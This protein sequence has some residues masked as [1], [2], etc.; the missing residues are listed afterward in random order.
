[1][2]EGVALLLCLVAVLIA[3]ATALLRRR[4]GRRR[5]LLSEDDWMWAWI[6]GFLITALLVFLIAWLAFEQPAWLALLIGFGSAI[7]AALY[8]VIGYAGP[9]REPEK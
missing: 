5:P 6:L 8:I 7:A 4:R 9:S 3:G 2:L 1:V